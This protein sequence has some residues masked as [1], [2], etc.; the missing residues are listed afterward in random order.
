MMI[1]IRSSRGLKD[2]VLPNEATVRDAVQRA[3]QEFG[4]SDAGGFG[5]VLSGNATLHLQP[6]R[7]L[8]SYEIREGSVLFLTAH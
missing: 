2:F 7:K 5:L 4:F 8:T 1:G 6:E 3:V